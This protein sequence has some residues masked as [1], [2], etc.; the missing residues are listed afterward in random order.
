MQMHRKYIFK[1]WFF[2]KN[3]QDKNSQNSK[4]GGQIIEMH[5]Q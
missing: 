3:Q 2:K 4:V 1:F 5:Q